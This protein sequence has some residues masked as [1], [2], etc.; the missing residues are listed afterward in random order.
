MDRRFCT[1]RRARH[2]GGWR[3]YAACF[4]A[5]GSSALTPGNHRKYLQKEGAAY[6]FE[7]FFCGEDPASLESHLHEADQRGS[8]LLAVEVHDESQLNAVWVALNGA[9]VVEVVDR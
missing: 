2:S 8:A 5:A 3:L 1:T 7:L 9:G 4:S 6:F